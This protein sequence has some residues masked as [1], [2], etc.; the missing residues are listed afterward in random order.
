M[1]EK[2][3][4]V[5]ETT[6]ALDLGGFVIRFTADGTV[7][8]STFSQSVKVSCSVELISPIEFFFIVC[9]SVRDPGFHLVISRGSQES[10]Q[11]S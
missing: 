5:I 11:K 3:I 10:V 6:Q 8:H 7:S 9:S 2:A 4:V 1:K